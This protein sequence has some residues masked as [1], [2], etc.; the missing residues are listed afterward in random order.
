MLVFRILQRFL[1]SLIPDDLEVN[2]LPFFSSADPA[3]LPHEAHQRLFLR[4]ALLGGHVWEVGGAIAA[5][6]VDEADTYTVRAKFPIH[7]IIAV[8]EVGQER[9][10]RLECWQFSFRDGVKP[11]VVDCGGDGIGRDALV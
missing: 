8:F 3:R 9:D 4:P 2:V 7:G 5:A 6:A 10:G 11:R 1:P